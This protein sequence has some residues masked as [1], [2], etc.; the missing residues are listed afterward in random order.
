MFSGVSLFAAQWTV[1]HQAPLSI[2]FYRQEYWSK[3]KAPFSFAQ[4]S[5]LGLMLYCC[6]LEILSNLQTRGLPFH[7]APGTHKFVD[8]AINSE[9]K[10]LYHYWQSVFF[11]SRLK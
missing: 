10:E 11:P 6:L 3:C 8:P 7:F 4:N 9:C 2:E 1:A 5:G